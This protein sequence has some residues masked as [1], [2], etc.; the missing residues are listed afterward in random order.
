[1]AVGRERVAGVD[2]CG[3]RVRFPAS[4]VLVAGFMVGAV[5]ALYVQLS[6]IPLDTPVFGL[7]QNQVD[8]EVYRQGALHMLHGQ[9][10]YD[11]PMLT[12]GL[13]YTYTPFSAIVFQPWGWMGA[14]M[15]V[16]VWSGLIIATLM[17]TCTPNLS[18]TFGGLSV[19]TTCFVVY[20][21]RPQDRPASRALM[22]ADVQASCMH[23]WRLV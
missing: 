15:A 7:F 21:C 11:G 9:P 16:A 6:F 1:M 13:L 19:R 22:L 14:D 8:L 20:S 12:N 10:L 4:V 17:T 3:E 23:S 2:A 18:D 5:I